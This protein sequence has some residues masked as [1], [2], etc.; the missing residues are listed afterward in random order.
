MTFS[1]QNLIELIKTTE[2]SYKVFK[3]QMSLQNKEGKELYIDFLQR[4]LTEEKIQ[5]ILETYYKEHYQGNEIKE[6]MLLKKPF[7]K[8][9]PL[10]NEEKHKANE[11]FLGRK[12]K[13]LV[14]IMNEVNN[15]KSSDIKDTTP[16][17]TEPVY[18]T[19]EYLFKEKDTQLNYITDL[20]SSLIKD[21]FIQDI[22]TN[23]NTINKWKKIFKGHSEQ[24]LFDNKIIWIGS[25]YQL[26]YLI[27]MLIYNDLIKFEFHNRWV[28]T[29]NCFRKGAKNRATKTFEITEYPSS[30]FGGTTAK[31]SMPRLR[32]INKHIKTLMRNLEIENKYKDLL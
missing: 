12:Y 28:I 11:Q 8:L 16:K 4:N 21:Q 26:K 29:S 20:Y 2:N 13:N 15:F 32:S 14:A 19:F 9:E 6:I 31:G 22:A 5:K 24:I 10:T 1:E 27:S 23:G 25:D 30:I 17:E 3:H 7:I 18:K